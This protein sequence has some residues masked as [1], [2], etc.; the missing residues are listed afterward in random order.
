MKNKSK[1][2]NNPGILARIA[3]LLMLIICKIL[4]QRYISLCIH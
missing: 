2:K 1:L 4:Y 3:F